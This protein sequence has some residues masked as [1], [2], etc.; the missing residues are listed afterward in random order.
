[1]TVQYIPSK[2]NSIFAIPEGGMEKEITPFWNNAFRDLK[3]I[4]LEWLQGSRSI[5]VFSFEDPFTSP[6]NPIRHAN[7]FVLE[8]HEILIL[9]PEEVTVDFLHAAFFYGYPLSIFKTDND[10]QYVENA[11]VKSILPMERRLRDSDFSIKILYDFFGE[12]ISVVAWTYLYR[13]E[14]KDICIS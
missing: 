12:F 7:S 8:D 10:D 1:M 14:E 6:K 3:T 2:S 5:W 13:I 9:R 11:F 4:L